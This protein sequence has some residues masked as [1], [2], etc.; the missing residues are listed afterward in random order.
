MAWVGGLQIT[1]DKSEAHSRKWNLSGKFCI[2]TIECS[3]SFYI[4]VLYSFVANTTLHLCRR[5]IPH[6]VFFLIK[7]MLSIYPQQKPLKHYTTTS[8]LVITFYAQ[9]S[10]KGLNAA[11]QHGIV[12]IQFPLLP[13]H[14]HYKNTWLVVA[15][16]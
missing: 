9:T 10:G 15:F 1:K 2:L 11:K 12:M 4:F 3:C 7:L 14:E 13:R 5:W 6:C 16:K 8:I